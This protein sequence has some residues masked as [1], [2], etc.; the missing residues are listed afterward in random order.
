MLSAT[1]ALSEFAQQIRGQTLQLLS[2]ADPAWLLWAPPG[3]SNHLLW[4]AGHALWAVDILSIEPI[5]GRSEL[6][7]HWAET[8]GA[9]CRPVRQ[10]QTWPARE[11]VLELLAA[12][13]NRYQQL[14]SEIPAERL[15]SEEPL[16]SGEPN[17]AWS[18]I[19]GWHDEAKHQ[20][21]MFLLSKMCRA[22]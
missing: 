17:L 12:Q 8:F 18:I 10:T 13:L 5:T 15:T 16:P 21:E 22:R 9:D 11:T 19:H 7:P 20:G 4:H 2:A 6:P 3:T 1:Y 14:L